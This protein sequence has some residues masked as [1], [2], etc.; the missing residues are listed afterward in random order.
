MQCL[1]FDLQLDLVLSI[2]Q[3]VVSH[4]GVDA[5]IL[6]SSAFYLQGAV[7]VDPVLTPI[8][9]TALAILKPSE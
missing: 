9:P 4:T 2:A 3:H 6:L 8:Q 7:D 5:L 1:T